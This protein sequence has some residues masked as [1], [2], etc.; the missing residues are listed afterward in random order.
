MQIWKIGRLS[1]CVKHAAF[2][3]LRITAAVVLGG[4]P[5]TASAIDPGVVAVKSTS[6]KPGEVAEQFEPILQPYEPITGGYTHDSDDTGFLDVN[7]SV[8]VRLLP[9]GFTS[10][11]GVTPYFAMAT[12]FGFYWG[13]R[14]NSP[15]IGKSYNPLLL[16]RVLT[17][18]KEIDS[19]DGRSTEHVGYI[20]ILPYAHE[21]NGQ[22]IHNQT[23][24]NDELNTL[25]NS[26]SPPLSMAEAISYTNNFIHRG[27]DYLG[28]VWKQS[29]HTESEVTTYTTYVEGRYFIPDGF[30]QGQEDEYHSW[31]KNPQG[32]PRKAVDGLSAMIE[33]PSSYAHFAVDSPNCEPPS[34]YT[35]QYLICEMRP[36]VTVKYLTGYDSPFKFSTERIELGFQV[37]SLP[38]ALWVQHGYMSS[39]AMYYV[40][41]NSAGLELRFDTF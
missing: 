31:E 40:K 19:P 14:P 15:V 11:W 5:A 16:V 12:R 25:K 23:G 33:Y 7:L 10:R 6:A 41:V 9:W 26:V 37:S 4:M 34:N 8:K 2:S 3:S 18:K 36:N 29:W 30:L 20:D 22:L 24:Y 27:W 1:A 38:I 35:L 28:A 13:T 17:T 21:S 39:L 32:K